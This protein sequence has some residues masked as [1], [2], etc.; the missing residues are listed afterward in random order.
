[1]RRYPPDHPIEWLR[2]AKDDL[3]AARVGPDLISPEILC[4]HA[5]QAAEKSLKAVLIDQSADFPFTHDIG[6]LLTILE[7]MGVSCVAG[8]PEANSLTRYA[9]SVRYPGLAEPVT[10]DEYRDALR[11]AEGI[12]AWA[13]GQ[14]SRRD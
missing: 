6:E 1:M 11:L 7:G 9:V 2:F 12:V 14:I 8:S 4:F 13:D 10:L 5:Q 3:N